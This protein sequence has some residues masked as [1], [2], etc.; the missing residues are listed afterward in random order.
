MPHLTAR[1]RSISIYFRVS[2]AL[3]HMLG[4]VPELCW[5]DTAIYSIL[6]SPFASLL[7]IIIQKEKKTCTAKYKQTLTLRTLCQRENKNKKNSLAEKFSCRFCLPIFKSIPGTF[8][9]FRGIF[10]RYRNEQELI[11]P[12]SA[13]P[14]S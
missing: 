13:E 12:S 9:F 6:R 4:S 5:E 11:F 3:F 1:Q 7:G 8:L 14:A 10:G 2:P